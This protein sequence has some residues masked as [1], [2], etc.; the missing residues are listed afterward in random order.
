MERWS[1]DPFAMSDPGT[2]AKGNYI[3]LGVDVLLIKT[4]PKSFK[5]EFY[6]KIS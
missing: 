3:R 1:N 4:S 5:A 6:L 2:G